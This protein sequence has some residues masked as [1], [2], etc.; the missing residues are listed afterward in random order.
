[1]AEAVIDQLTLNRTLLQRQ[2]LLE[3]VARPAYE[4]IEHLVGMQAQEP[5]D[6]YISLWSRIDGFD[7]GEL[8]GLLE[9]RR[10]VRANTLWRTTIHLVTDRDAPTLRALTQPLVERTF[11]RTQFGRDVASLPMDELLADGRRLLEERPRSGPQLA[12]ALAGRWPDCPPTSLVQAVRWL[13]PTVQVPPRAVWGRSAPPTLAPMDSWL[14]RPIPSHPSPDDVVLRYLAA[15][16]PA[17]V[18]DMRSWS[19]LGAMREVVDRLGDRLRTYRDESGRVLHDLADG[20]LAAPDLPAPPRFFGN[21]DNLFLG[22]AERSR[23]VPADARQETSFPFGGGGTWVGTFTHDGFAAGVWR[24]DR[25]TD[26]PTL[27]LRAFRQLS[28]SESVDL[29]AEGR[30]LAQL[31]LGPGTDCRIAFSRPA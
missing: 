26:T 2:L 9:G 24:L 25:T 11:R 10:A 7:P 15:F 29:E 31:I 6:P 18:A 3:R 1:M 8:A 12:A 17:S 4:V 20:V 19:G 21:Y 13:L 30:S 5:F 27:V 14:D 22:H 28:A 23:I 16:G